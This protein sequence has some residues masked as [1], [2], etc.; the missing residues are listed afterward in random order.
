MCTF[1][2]LGGIY[3][4]YMHTYIHVYVREFIQTYIYICKHTNIQTYKTNHTYRSLIVVHTL[5][6]M[7]HS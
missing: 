3:M 5:T 6:Q 2:D 1:G 4:T 7:T